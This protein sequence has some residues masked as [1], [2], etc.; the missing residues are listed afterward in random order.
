MRCCASNNASSDIEM[1][2]QTASKLSRPERNAP[3]AGAALPSLESLASQCSIGVRE[4]LSREFD[5]PGKLDATATTLSLG[6]RSVS[7][8]K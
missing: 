3:N 1:S 8:S 4:I 7:F 2:K 6:R 5:K